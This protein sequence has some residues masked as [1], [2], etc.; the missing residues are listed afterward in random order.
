MLG[1]WSEKELGRHD[2]ESMR[3]GGGWGTPMDEV[4][5]PVDLSQDSLRKKG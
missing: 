2:G 1:E 3:A 5:I 4:A